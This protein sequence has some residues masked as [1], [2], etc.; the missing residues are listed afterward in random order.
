[1]SDHSRIPVA[2]SMRPALHS[3]HLPDEVAPF[4]R[5]VLTICG[6]ALGLGITAAVVARA[7][8]SLIGLI[9]NMAF[10]GRWSTSFVGPAGTAL[11]AAAIVAIPALGGLIVGVMARYGSAAIRGHCIP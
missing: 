9:T 2:P 7:L 4:E 1:M 10:Y 6:L 3:V 8:T 11:P 5:R